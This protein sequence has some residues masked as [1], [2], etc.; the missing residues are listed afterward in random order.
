[1]IVP[2]DKA[3]MHTYF[4]ESEWK[5]ATLSVTIETVTIEPVAQL[6]LA[7][8]SILSAF[9]AGRPTCRRFVLHIRERE[10]DDDNR[11][12]TGRAVPADP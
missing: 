9:R 2:Q 10:H 7:V 4:A 1:M 12:R 6:G 11:Q 8:R 5:A 3:W